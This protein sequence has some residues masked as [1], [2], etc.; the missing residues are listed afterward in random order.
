[1]NFFF[2]FVNFKTLQVLNL[3]PKQKKI[4]GLTFLVVTRLSCR[5][6]LWKIFFFYNVAEVTSDARG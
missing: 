3:F 1:M 2:L 4:D 5:C 6:Y